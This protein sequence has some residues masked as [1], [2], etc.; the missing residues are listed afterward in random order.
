MIKFMMPY[1]RNQLRKETQL[2]E[3]HREKSVAEPSR[4]SY[5]RQREFIMAQQ[6][7]LRQNRINP[8]NWFAAQQS[9]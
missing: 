5:E 6:E 3:L 4:V 9:I 1:W 2:M 7:R 8:K